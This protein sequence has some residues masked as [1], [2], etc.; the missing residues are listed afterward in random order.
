MSARKLAKASKWTSWHNLKFKTLKVVPK[1]YN[2]PSLSWHTRLSI[3]VP[4]HTHSY[5][6]RTEKIMIVISDCKHFF[7]P[8]KKFHHKIFKNKK[9]ASADI[10]ESENAQAMI[11]DIADFNLEEFLIS[12]AKMLVDTEKSNIIRKSAAYQIKKVLKTGDQ[13]ETR[14]EYQSR[15]FAL[16][17][18]VRRVLKESVL[19]C[20][21]TEI[22]TPNPAPEL[23]AFIASIE[24]PNEQW[25]DLISELARNVTNMG[26]SDSMKEA[27]LV[28]IA[29]LCHQNYECERC[30]SMIGNSNEV[31]KS[32]FQG[33]LH[34]TSN[35]VMTAAAVALREWIS[36]KKDK[37]KSNPQVKSAIC[38]I[39]ELALSGDIRIKVAA[40]KCLRKF[41]LSYLDKKLS[42]IMIEAVQSE[43][44]E[45][46]LQGV[47]FW[48]EQCF[49]ESPK[50]KLKSDNIHRNYFTK[51]TLPTILPIF[52]KTLTVYGHND[53]DG[54]KLWILAN[55]S[56][57]V[58]SEWCDVS[59]LR[60]YLT[61]FIQEHIRDDD[62]KYRSNALLWTD[63][64]VIKPLIEK[65]MPIFIEILAKD[66]NENVRY[67]TAVVIGG[68]CSKI[69]EHYMFMTHL[70]PLIE[71]LLKG[72]KDVP[73]VVCGICEVWKFY[74]CSNI[75][76]VCQFLSQAIED[77]AYKA[78]AF[79]E[80]K[81]TFCLSQYFECIVYSLLE[82]LYRRDGSRSSRSSVYNA[83]KCLLQ[84]SA[85]DCSFIFGKLCGVFAQRLQYVQ[86]PPESSG[87]NQPCDGNDTE[88]LALLRTLQTLIRLM[89]PEN[90]CKSFNK[91]LSGLMHILRKQRCQL[92][93]RAV[94][95]E[96]I[97]LIVKGIGEKFLPH[98]ELLLPMLIIDLKN[99]K[100]EQ[101]CIAAVQLLHAICNA[102]EEKFIPYCD[103]I[104]TILLESLN[105]ENTNRRIKDSILLTIGD[106]AKATGGSFKKYLDII[107]TTLVLVQA[108][109]DKEY[110]MDNRV[111]A[112]FLE[113]QLESM[114]E[115]INLMAFNKSDFKE[116]DDFYLSQA[117]TLLKSIC[118]VFG[119]SIQ[120]LID[121]TGV[122]DILNSGLLIR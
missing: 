121:A 105:N 108:Q 62:W 85:K 92:I 113:P 35:D 56:M 65:A 83:L 17:P 95:L 15:W 101:T 33:L 21:G 87:D 118:S 49:E 71:S 96:T 23:L 29:R 93:I 99:R 55:D 37:S 109:V 45:I 46:R 10:V 26:N 106:I 34:V 86:Q 36:L 31:F 51:D 73:R 81:E 79:S 75:N 98:V 84:Y 41:Q 7:L 112:L 52:L 76:F 116:M 97:S 11:D 47:K 1:R 61:C 6:G 60:Q 102:T 82:T 59:S 78:Y 63:W 9:S 50:I 32:I 64:H 53:K 54:N 40:L 27:S 115:V 16:R 111:Y 42:K 94:T 67:T 13:W 68:V 90:L 110:L 69:Q 5:L 2:L 44:S 39:F 72:L 77:I 48:Y 57:R 14:L 4:V 103:P 18:N 117:I 30:K 120:H 122:I 25:P 19:S 70:N 22:V 38:R 24:L 88:A 43:I 8:P 80:T 91:I 3:L 58:L 100:K 107:L 28:A 104:I 12:L 74:F 20:L 89:V 114:L 119:K 66:D